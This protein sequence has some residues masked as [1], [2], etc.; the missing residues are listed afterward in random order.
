MRLMIEIAAAALLVF[1]TQRHQR[2][3]AAIPAAP[4]DGLSMPRS[5]SP[6]TLRP[7]RRCAANSAGMRRKIL[8]YAN[9]VAAPDAVGDVT[10]ERKTNSRVV[11]A[12]ARTHNHTTAVLAWGQVAPVPDCLLDQPRPSNPRCQFFNVFSRAI[13]SLGVGIRFPRE[14]DGNRYT[15]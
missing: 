2:R 6:R 11:P 3:R 13:A 1:C 10:F 8:L 7:R 4:A 9:Y 5:V 15:S 12:K 14:R